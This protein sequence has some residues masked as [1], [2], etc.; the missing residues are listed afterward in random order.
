[1]MNH[2]RTIIAVL[3]HHNILYWEQGK[4]VSQDS[5]NVQCPYCGDQSNHCGIFIK[6]M[7]YHCW[8]CNRTGTLPFLLAYITRQSVEECKEQI[9]SFGINFS[10]DSAN[11]IEDLW[12][13][14]NISVE[15]SSDSNTIVLPEYFEPVT[16]Q[17]DFPLLDSYLKRRDISRQILIDHHCGICTVGSC[18]NRLVIPV[19]FEGQLASYQAADLTGCSS[20]KY[21]TA[22]NQINQFL[23]RWDYLDWSLGYVILVEGVLDAWRLGGNTLATFGTSLTTQQRKLL[24]EKK[25][26]CLVFCWDGDAWTFAEKEA[27]ELRAFIP[28]ISIIYLPWDQDPDNQDPDSFGFEKTWKEIS[29]VVEEVSA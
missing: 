10:E 19:Y 13:E 28:H 12:S 11:Q 22:S 16:E 14:S 26:S 20:L 9:E 23:Y 6:D 21:Q 8:R 3:E 1:V 25:I 29:C 15:E 4:N 27:D 5:I 18:M 2:A 24:I 7:G 17:L